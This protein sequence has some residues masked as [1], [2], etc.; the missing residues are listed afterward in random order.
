MKIFVN[1]FYKSLW[2]GLVEILVEWCQR[3]LHDLVQVLV[4]RS[5]GDPVEILLKRSLHQDLEDALL[6]CLYE[7]FSGMLI[8]R[9]CMKILWDP[10]YIHIYIHVYIYIYIYIYIDIYNYIYIYIYLYRRSYSAVAILSN[11]LFHSYC[12]L[13]LVHWLP[14]PHTVWGLLPV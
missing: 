6:W 14:T 11:L 10:I 8:G 3:P 7:S 2:D 13:Y 4:R 9:S 1:V 5:C 12:C